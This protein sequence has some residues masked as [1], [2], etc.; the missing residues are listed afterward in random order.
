MEEARSVRQT[1]C[2]DSCDTHVL[3][4]RVQFFFEG[5]SFCLHLLHA[6]GL[7]AREVQGCCESYD[8]SHI[9]RS[10]AQAPLLPS[11]AQQ[12]DKARAC[13]EGAD[14]RAHPLRSSDFVR[15][16]G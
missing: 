4:L 10:C 15:R 3:D 6:F 14:E 9:L 12:R 13:F 2:L 11:A 8:C 5:V 7:L 16:Q 1:R